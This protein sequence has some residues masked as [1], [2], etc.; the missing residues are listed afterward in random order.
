MNLFA[1]MAGGWLKGELEKKKE[2]HE[3]LLLH[4]SYTRWQK[5]IFPKPL[6][7]SEAKYDAIDVKMMKKLL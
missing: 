6:F 4:V 2:L 1:I 7:Q 3:S 5:A